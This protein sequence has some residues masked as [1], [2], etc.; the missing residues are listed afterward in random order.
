MKPGDT[1]AQGKYTLLRKL[2]S[3]GMAEVWLARQ[4]G[5]EGFAKDIVIKRILPHLAEDEK[6]VTMF[7]DEARIAA[8]LN[9]PNVVQIFDLGNEGR[10]YFIAMEYIRGYDIEQIQEQLKQRNMPFP[11]EIG[12]Q[13]VSDT[14]LGLAYAHDCKTPDGAPMQVVHR[15]VS[16]QNILVSETGVVKLIDFGIAKART[17]STRTQV[18]HTKGK[19][20]YM[21]PEQM[22]A[23]ELD[24]RS[25]IF[26]LGVVMYEAICNTKPF[27]GDNLLTCYHNLKRGIN[28]PRSCR[29]DIPTALAQ[30]M[31][32]ALAYDREERY[33]TATALRY[34]LQRYLNAEGIS[35][36]PEHLADF[37]T[38]LFAPPES[39]QFVFDLPR[40][41]PMQSSASQSK[42]GEQL[43]SIPPLN[44]DLDDEI[45]TH[46]APPFI[47]PKMYRPAPP[48]APQSSQA[49]Y[50]APL[51]S[52][53]TYQNPV[54][55]N[56]PAR[57]APLSAN[58]EEERTVANQDPFSG[59][60]IGVPPS[61]KSPHLT[62]AH[63][64]SV[65]FNQTGPEIGTPMVFE[66]ELVD[67]YQPRKAKKR[68]RSTSILFLLLPLF[69]LGGAFAGAY[70]SGLFETNPP[71]S[72]PPKIANISDAG[73]PEFAHTDLKSHILSV[74]AP[75]NDT[76]TDSAEHH[77]T[78]TQPKPPPK[79][80]QIEKPK[81]RLRPKPRPR[82]T[83]YRAVVISIDVGYN[84]VVSINGG[85]YIKLPML[86]QIRLSTGRKHRFFFLWSNGSETLHYD[87][88]PGRGIKEL[89]CRIRG[90]NV[91]CVKRDI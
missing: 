86:K 2:R 62:P 55:P 39:T 5:T 24:R 40:K 21:S 70:F 17:S 7:L 9:H 35:I 10:N 90:S 76:K 65:A 79:R 66:D 37:L 64:L 32:K 88:R 78:N 47:D 71:N 77:S 36:G 29:P 26:S 44:L 51:N 89:Y 61:L 13:I 73:S 15:D 4:H 16:P 14:C 6:L 74:A 75:D 18:G 28:E 63:P 59:Y 82:A 34:E 3:S 27:D 67:P 83:S 72:S 42:R 54:P 19:I 84:A 38:W 30:I 91:S 12:V 48:K 58:I 87:F 11:I 50:V 69:L 41:S 45:T 57:N 85:E 8:H 52:P 25:D 31:Q 49:A 23:R 22:M 81:P 53:R 33:P 60:S 46:T 56:S 1:L 68:S 80:P 20:C 43:P